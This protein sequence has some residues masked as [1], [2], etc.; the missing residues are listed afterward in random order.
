MKVCQCLMLIHLRHSQFFNEQFLNFFEL[1]DFIIRPIYLCILLIYEVLIVLS[2][3]V[4]DHAL[5]F[6]FHLQELSFTLIDL[7]PLTSFTEVVILFLFYSTLE[8]LLL[9][10]D[11]DAFC[12]QYPLLRQVLALLQLGRMGFL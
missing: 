7:V 9:L 10:C 11:E 12:S 2:L 6:K 1:I 8:E 3:L 5:T 4:F